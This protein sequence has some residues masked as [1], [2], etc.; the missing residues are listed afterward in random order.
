GQDAAARRAFRLYLVAHS[1]GGLICR[2]LIQNPRVGSAEARALVDKVFTYATPHNGIDLNIIGNVPGFVSFNDADTF[3]RARMA[4]YLDLPG[5]A[6][7]VDS[8]NGRFDPDRFFCLV[9]SDYRDYAESSA[10]ARRLVGAMS[11]GL[12]R[13]ENATIRGAPRAFVYRSH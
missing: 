6:D 9:G 11:D 5:D 10:L 12:V 7:R 4:A 1:M 3:N 8:L 13:I 2:C